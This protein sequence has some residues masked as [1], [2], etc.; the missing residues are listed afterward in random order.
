MS[1]WTAGVPQ[2][3]PIL[4]EK[5]ITQ[6]AQAKVVQHHYVRAQVRTIEGNA[7]SVIADT[8]NALRAR[9]EYA[10]FSDNQLYPV[11][12]RMTTSLQNA[13]ICIN[14]KA[15][16]WFMQPNNYDSYTQMYERGVRNI[17][18]PG[19]KV[20]EMRLADDD[21]NDAKMRVIADDIVTFPPHMREGGNKYKPMD[22]KWGGMGRVMM[23]GNMQKVEGADEYRN[24][25]P[26]FNPKSKQV[27]AA[28]NYGRRPHGASTGYGYSYLV[29]KRKLMT[30]MIF[31]ACDTFNYR[32]QNVS[33]EHQ[34]SFLLLGALYGKAS[35][36]LREDLFKSCVANF[37]LPDTGNSLLLV[38]G[39]LFEPL[40]FEGNIEAMHVSRL[41]DKTGVPLA[42]GPWA[43][44]K[45][46]ATKFH[47]K[48]ISGRP[49]NAFID[50]GL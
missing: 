43:M 49:Q 6:V 46:N 37:K 29:L 12:Q 23:P 36:L 24:T 45:A 5:E 48:F 26:H 19:G 38:E 17:D 22:A 14:F 10:K 18:A 42:N 7:E 3:K 21:I 25:N 39:H 20:P 27:F 11:F 34:I 33:A 41:D 15:S 50:T 30:N 1:S 9:A 4:Q 32:T 31:F 44:I 16:K 47:E 35:P 2:K 28:L 13:E 40:K 8:L